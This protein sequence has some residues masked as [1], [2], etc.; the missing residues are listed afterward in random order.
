MS[1][2]RT[3]ARLFSQL[4]TVRQVARQGLSTTSTVNAQAAMKTGDAPKPK[5]QPK[6]AKFNWEDPFD[7]ESQFTE[8]EKMIRDTAADYA[9]SQLMPRIV[10]ANRHESGHEGMHR[11]A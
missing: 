2:L 4:H 6:F 3:S 10:E 8:E 9:Q 5:G 11:E 1:S 7:I